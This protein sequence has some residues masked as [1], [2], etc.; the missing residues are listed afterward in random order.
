M[1]A[2]D[3]TG[4][5]AHEL[6]RALGE[7]KTSS[8]EITK[9]FLSRIEEVDERVHAYLHWDAEDMLAQAKRS[10]ARRSQGQ[11]KGPLDGIPVGLKDVICV[12]G[13]PL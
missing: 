8:E 9:A 2:S 6:S 13:Q 7:G 11:S 3:L 4:S 10:D 1:I 12:E 5:T